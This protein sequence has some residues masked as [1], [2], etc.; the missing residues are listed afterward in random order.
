MII[1]PLRRAISLPHARV[2]PD[3]ETVVAA[4]TQFAE[5]SAERDVQVVVFDAEHGTSA[6]AVIVVVFANW[7]VNDADLHAFSV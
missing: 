5:I 2:H 1:E 7:R 3:V 6:Q 4:Q